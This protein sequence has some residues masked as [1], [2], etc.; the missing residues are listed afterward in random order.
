MAAS[1]DKKPRPST[2]DPD[3]IAHFSAIAAQWWDPHG[4]F[5]P[6]HQ[7]NPLRIAYIRDTLSAH[8]DRDPLGPKPLAGLKVLDIGCGG[9]L[10]CE[11][12]HRLGA[13]ITGADAAD[14][15]I[16]TATTHAAEHG[17]AIDY[18][19]TTAEQLAA[20]G[21][22]FDAI[23]NME[24][25]EHVANVPIF[26]DACT[27]LIKPGGVMLCATL[28]RTLKS[29]GLA[30]IAAEYILGW[31]PRGTHNWKKFITPT[32]LDTALREAGLSPTARTGMIYNPISGR[33]SLSRDTDVNYIVRAEKRVSEKPPH[34]AT[35]KPA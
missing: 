8:F 26:L 30:V 19:T 16:K 18:R 32:E 20:A 2:V 24:V 9:G 34:P 29:F 14:K 27:T 33:W 4:K 12:M 1:Q 7:L 17:L 10:L 21:E 28:N 5:R 35:H 13:D 22:R 11:P 6:L 23:L 3:E 25:I 31:L 15:N